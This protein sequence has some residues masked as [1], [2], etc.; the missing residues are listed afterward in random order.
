ML[1]VFV[2]VEVKAEHAAAFEAATMANARASIEEPGVAR[3]DVL[4]TDG[5]PN[6][7]V[8]IEVYRDSDA[9]AAHKLTAHYQRWRDEVEPMM[10]SPRRSVRYTNVFPDDAGW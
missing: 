4:R 5:K 7:F 6:E 3:F 8:L 1:V 9:P 10:A 2:H